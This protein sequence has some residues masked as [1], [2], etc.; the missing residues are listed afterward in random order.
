MDR[1]LNCTPEGCAGST[2]FPTRVPAISELHLPCP[3]VCS[4]GP[5]LRRP[6]AGRQWRSFKHHWVVRKKLCSKAGREVS[7]LGF[8]LLISPVSRIRGNPAVAKGRPTARM[9]G[10]KVSRPISDL[11]PEAQNPRTK[12]VMIPHDT[13]VTDALLH[14]ILPC[15]FRSGTIAHGICTYII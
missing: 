8:L 5:S 7:A 3:V 6:I 12:K 9:T 14:P 13:L 10:R 2:S 11:S 15:P 4:K 1:G